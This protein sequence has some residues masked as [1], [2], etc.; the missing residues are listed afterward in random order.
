MLIKHLFKW[1]VI[2]MKGLFVAAVLLFMVQTVSAE[3]ASDGNIIIN[4]DI[5]EY[6]SQN[7]TFL[8]NLSA[9]D[10]SVYPVASGYIYF[11]AA[12]LKRSWIYFYSSN[13]WNTTI[14]AIFNG[15]V[16]GVE[17]YLPSDARYNA[18]QTIPLKFRS[19][20]VTHTVNFSV[21]YYIL[22]C[23]HNCGVQV[24]FA[25]ENITS[26]P[27]YDPSVHITVSNESATVFEGVP[28]KGVEYIRFSEG[29]QQYIINWDSSGNP[30]GEY[31]IT[32]S[33][34]NGYESVK[35]I[36]LQ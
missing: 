2:G 19:Q 29:N 17:W 1:I 35:K 5:P 15:G 31:N 11:D 14:K 23:Y 34:N 36:M 25:E 30:H 9:I 18:G 6:V 4:I 28:G 3:T 21:R 7:E 10:L 26:S 12:L 27:V 16:G 24:I 32:A 33:F 8:I 22:D 13:V 20:K